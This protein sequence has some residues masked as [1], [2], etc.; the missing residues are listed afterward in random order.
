MYVSVSV[1]LSVCVCVWRQQNQTGNWY[2]I[3]VQLKKSN[4]RKN[5]QIFIDC[6]I[7][8]FDVQLSFNYYDYHI[9]LTVH[10]SFAF[11]PQATHTNEYE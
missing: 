6:K 9:D 2:Y 3:D 1:S 5:N 11:R 10:L 4:D 7:D 8:S